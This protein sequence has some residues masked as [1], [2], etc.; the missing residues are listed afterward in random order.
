MNIKDS[1]EYETTNIIREVYDIFKGNLNSDLC[2]DYILA[3]LF[4]KYVNDSNKS[5]NSL[6]DNKEYINNQFFI[7]KESR[8]DYLYQ[9][10][11]NVNIGEIINIAFAS[12][13]ETNKDKL[14]GRDG[15]SIFCNIDFNSTN[16]G[17]IKEKNTRLR[18]LLENFNDI[19]LD[20]SS[21]TVKNTS[22]I[23]DIYMQLIEYFAITIGK[24]ASVFITPRKV[25]SLLALL[26]QSEHGTKIFDPT[27]GSG[28][29]LIEAGKM[30][31]DKKVSLYGQE[32]NGNMWAMAKMNMLLHGYDDAVI[33]WGDTLRDP[34]LLEDD[35]LMKFDI[36]LAAPPFSSNNWGEEEAQFDRF[37]RFWRGVPPRSKGNWA[38]ISHMI[39][40]AYEDKGKIGVIIPHGVLFRGGKEKRI[41]KQLIDENYL[42]AVIGLPSNL[43]YGTGIPTAIM[44]FNKGKKNRNTLFIDASQEYQSNKNQNILRDEDFN[45]IL[46]V[47]NKFKEDRVE[48]KIVEDKYAYIATLDEIRV[49]DYNLNIPLYV[50]S[51]EEGVKKDTQIILE[52][53]AELEHQ[54]L[55]KRE[56]ISACLKELG[57]QI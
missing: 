57:F 29:L 37:N 54:L 23:G 40:V 43:Y 6:K 18:I 33:R 16:L 38:F 5:L 55:Y 20:I 47:F 24:Q 41:R 31:E 39:E 3:I 35:K 48:S 12:L 14:K 51:S 45:H 49:N 32:L 17:N 11:E 34:K 8:F 15:N 53:I 28:S 25:C 21:T 27:C 19:E 36:V 2:K 50:H 52:E 1:I 56:S 22:T 10:R 9:E 30:I 7:P 46:S 42:E 44:V 4:L 26:T 13:E